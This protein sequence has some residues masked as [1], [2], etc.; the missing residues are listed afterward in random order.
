MRIPTAFQRRIE[1]KP[2]GEEGEWR[3]G[4]KN[5]CIGNTTL[6]IIVLGKMRM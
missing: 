2:G 1:V 6:L 3:G 4:M 5:Y